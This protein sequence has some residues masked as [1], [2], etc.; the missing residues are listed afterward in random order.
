MLK[1]VTR[2]LLSIITGAN[3]VTILLLLATGYSDRIDPVGH[4]MLACIGMAFPLMLLANLLFLLLWLCV[5]WRRIWIPIAGFALA[6][7]PIRTYIPLRLRPQPPQDALLVVS[8][9]VAGFNAGRNADALDSICAYL[10]RLQPDIVCLQEDMGVGKGRPLERLTELF[11]YNDTVHVN[12]VSQ[13]YINAVGLHSRFPILKHEV[14][15]YGSAT[16]GSAAFFLLVGTDTVVVVNNHLE[17]THLTPDER[18]RYKEV[19]KGDMETDSAR[20]E[21]RLLV[22]KISERMALRAPQARA[23]RSYVEAHSRYPVIVCGDFNDTPISFARRTIAKGLADCFVESGCGLGL[24]YNQKGFYFRID[25]MMCSSHFTPVRCE[26]DSKIDA[27]DHYPLIS[28][29]KKVDKP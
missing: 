16:N 20:K 13:T 24:S 29:L 18:N 14:I 7:M 5:K 23:V 2:V 12:G 19:L 1:I 17:S 28:W 15:E 10:K 8:Y 25:H 26:I 9:N 11:D 6:Y 22:G 3:V 4:P 27:S 21:T